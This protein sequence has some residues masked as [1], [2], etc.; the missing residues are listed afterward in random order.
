MLTSV[1]GG[2]SVGPAMVRDFRGVLEREKADLGLFICLR[3]P[4]REMLREA[5]SAGYADTVH[6]EIPKLQIVA[7]EEWFNK[8]LP[9]LPP[10]EHLP[11]AA[12]ATSRRRALPK[13]RR[14]DP[15]A[16]ELPLSYRGGKSLD[17]THLNPGMVRSQVEQSQKKLAL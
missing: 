12:L 14:P 10:L 1:K 16:P 2:D 13:G 9:I 11:I 15:A 8:K 5:T 3:K 6:G 4:T 7:I 17:V